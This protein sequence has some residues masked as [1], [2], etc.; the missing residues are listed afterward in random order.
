MFWWCKPAICHWAFAHRQRSGVLVGRVHSLRWTGGSQDLSQVIIPNSFNIC[1]RSQSSKTAPSTE[2]I[3]YTWGSIPIITGSFFGINKT[4]WRQLTISVGWKIIVMAQISCVCVR[5]RHSWYHITALLLAS[6]DGDNSS[7]HYHCRLTV[8]P[9]QSRS[10]LALAF[11]ICATT[12]TPAEQ[13]Q[14]AQ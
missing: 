11:S 6:S 7:G 3:R 1:I 4:D 10:N 5:A 2:S 9:T 12:V 8:L 14:T 13:T